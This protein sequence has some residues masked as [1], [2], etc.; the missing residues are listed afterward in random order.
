[1][2]TDTD[3]D[4]VRTIVYYTGFNPH[5]R[6]KGT[7]FKL[8]NGEI[9]ETPYLQDHFSYFDGRLEHRGLSTTSKDS[10]RVGLVFQCVHLD[11]CNKFMFEGTCGNDERLDEI[12]SK[13]VPR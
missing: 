8:E 13:E 4:N 7:Q 1:M 10:L 2:D 3:E 11:V 12:I 6:H 5:H 9:A